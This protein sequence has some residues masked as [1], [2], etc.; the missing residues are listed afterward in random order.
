[1]PQS[2]L[3]STLQS[4]RRG[5]PAIKNT[6]AGQIG[7]M[8]QERQAA[9]R[10][11]QQN[12]RDFMLDKAQAQ[13]EMRRRA[14][15]SSK[16]QQELQRELAD[17]RNKAVFGMLQEAS[18]YADSPEQLRAFL[19]QRPKF[20][21]ATG[22]NPENPNPDR[23]RALR[24]RYEVL[25]TGER[26]E[27]GEQWRPLTAS[28]KQQYGVPEGTAAQINDQ[29]GKIQ[30]ESGQT[31]NV[32]GEPGPY[33][34]AKEDVIKD[35]LKAEVEARNNAQ[36]TNQLTAGL[37]DVMGEGVTTGA[38]QPALTGLQNLADSVGI[39]LGSF[40]KGLGLNIGN[41]EKKEEFNRLTQ[42]LLINQFKEF[43]GNLNDREV[44]I[45]RDSVTSLGSSEEANIRAIAAMR[46][47]AM[48]AQRRAN[49]K[50]M[51]NSE[52]EMRAIDKRVQEQGLEE[53]RALRDEIMERLKRR[54]DLGGDQGE[55]NQGSEAKSE[56]ESPQSQ[57]DPLGIRQ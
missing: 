56:E 42:Q 53:Y 24:D 2:G 3:A 41:L 19:S 25:T 1:M 8:Q 32:G 11:A 27:R 5:G 37:V 48:L 22:L 21:E 50:L 20:A 12:L 40:A 33:A 36:Q 9:Q 26:P 13:S 46:A 29:T 31:I 44:R 7:A 28:E 55:T 35:E 6:L 17:R 4:I 34:G 10:E 30:T 57:D 23:V 52:E 47:S 14:F 45:A 15:K 39:D 18:R 49:E 43:K 54:A 16:E 38:I 51:A